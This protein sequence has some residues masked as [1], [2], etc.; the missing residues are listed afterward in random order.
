MEEF[1]VRRTIRIRAEPSQV[2]NALTNPQKTKH[3]FFNCEVFSDW[4]VGSTILFTGRI[5]LLKK[6]EMK[7]QIIKIEPD[8][9]LEYTLSNGEDEDDSTNFSTIRDELTYEKGETI[10][11]ITDNVGQSEGAE[12]RYRR[13]EK[14]WDNILKGLKELVEAENID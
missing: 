9:L 4:E 6:I 10:L 14:G 5:F 12:D 8:K 7:G 2:W 13:S 3:Y 1:I 11:S